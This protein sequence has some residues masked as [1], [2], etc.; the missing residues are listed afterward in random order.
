MTTA[1][2][3]RYGSLSATG[4]ARE[5]ATTFGTPVVPTT[6][7]PMTGNELQLDPGL[8][9][10]KVMF[11]QRDVNTF[12]LFGQYKNSG[13]LAAALF[14]TNGALFIPGA[15]GPDAQA[16]FGVIGTVGT[17]ST[18]TSGT[19]TA[20]TTTVNVT[21]AAG[22]TQGQVIQIDVN[23][24]VGPTTAECR[25]ITNIVTNTLTIDSAISYNHASGVNVIG[26]VAPYTHSVQQANQ[27]SSFTIEKNLGSFESLQF[28]GSRV[29]KLSIAATSTDAEATMSVDAVAKSVA[30]LASPSAITI[31]NESPFVFAEA[32]VSL[33][34]QNVLQASSFTLDIDNG[35]KST[36]TMNTTHNLNFL[37]PVTRH[38][39]G[40]IDVV[41]TSLDDATWGYFNQMVAGTSG[42]LTLSLTH[43]ASGGSVSF[44]MP[45]V[46]LK[47]AADS[48]KFEDVI[49]TS[50]E[51]EVF[52][53][54]ATLQT[55]SATIINQSY[56]PL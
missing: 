6:F 36:Y 20:G 49:M 54:L 30:V 46:L 31:T 38:V 47:K 26:V 52:L 12:P 50:L 42:T 45:K 13:G 43:P 16:S 51:Y 53:N 44:T 8:F 40:K 25:K 55:I 4:A 27:L 56:L 24:T 1:V 41:F 3:E 9:S 33:F 15:I 22:F 2:V 17:G 35:L 34:G 14:P 7:L 32:S 10:P 19:L 23:N 21:S 29:G 18:T 39:S 28:A 48:V 37:T 5:G 11:G